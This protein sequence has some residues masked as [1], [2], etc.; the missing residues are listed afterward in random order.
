MEDL[1]KKELL[2]NEQTRQLQGS[3]LP[4]DFADVLVIDYDWNHAAMMS[5]E[6][7]E[8]LAK[9]AGGEL[10]QLVPPDNGPAVYRIFVK[11]D[12]VKR[13]LRFTLADYIDYQLDWRLKQI[14]LTSSQRGF[15]NSLQKA[16]KHLTESCAVLVRME[17]MHYRDFYELSAL[18]D[19]FL[20]FFH[21]LETI[22][23]M[24]GKPSFVKGTYCMI[25]IPGSYAF[26]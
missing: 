5:K 17:A 12:K 10:V 23:Q 3:T 22:S 20:K 18:E 15:S 8:Q 26:F 2:N 11:G 7:A 1:M 9:D 4:A 21:Q 16:R 13:H 19:Y 24:Y 6:K 25:L 14:R